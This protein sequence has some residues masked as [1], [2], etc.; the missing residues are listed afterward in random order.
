[1]DLRLI[2]LEL[3]SYRCR[4][5]QGM[6][7]LLFVCTWISIV[8]AFVIISGIWFMSAGFESG[9]TV[10]DDCYDGCVIL[11]WGM[12]GGLSRKRMNEKRHWGELL[13]FYDTTVHARKNLHPTRS[14]FS[15]SIHYNSRK[16]HEANDRTARQGS[17]Q[18]QRP[19]P[20]SGP[21]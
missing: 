10:R 16:G 18:G 20:L 4:P 19:A 6:R 1:M 17:Y 3:F 15:F 21:A 13:L 2:A 14:R 8:N 7:D 9:S 5:L 11:D 12:K